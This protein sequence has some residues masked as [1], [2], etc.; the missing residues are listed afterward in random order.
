MAKLEA[1]LRLV[2]GGAKAE[3]QPFDLKIKTQAAAGRF[4]WLAPQAA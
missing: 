1:G 2:R 4:P 3:D